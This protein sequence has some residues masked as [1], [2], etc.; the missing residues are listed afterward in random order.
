MAALRFADEAIGDAVE[1]VASLQGGLMDG[2]IFFRRNE[3]GFSSVC[4]LCDSHQL[5]ALP[6]AVIAGSSG[7]D[8]VKILRIALRLHE[9]LPAA[10]GTTGEVREFLRRAIKRRNDGFALQ[11]R[12]VDGPI[13]EVDQLLGVPAAKLASVPVCPVSVE[14]MA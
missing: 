12:F 14:A 2:G 13:T 5:N 1:R 11:G 9:S 7:D 4:R 6:G 10:P 8:T 3:A